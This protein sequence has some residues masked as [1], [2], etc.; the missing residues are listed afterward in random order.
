MERLVVEDFLGIREADVG[1]KKFNVIIG[2]QKNILT[3]L[4]YFFR[5]TLD[6]CIDTAILRD[7]NPEKTI[8]K[9]FILHFPKYLWENQKFN[10]EYKI[11][12]I[13]IRVYY[14]NGIRAV[15]NKTFKELITEIR[16]ARKN[17]TSPIAI[18]RYIKGSQASVNNTIY[19]PTG[20]N[21]FPKVIEAVSGNG[22]KPPKLA[23]TDLNLDLISREFIN[24]Y[25]IADYILER[26]ALFNEILDDVF[27]RKIKLEKHGTIRIDNQKMKLAD[28]PI[29]YQELV[30][31]LTILALPLKTKESK[32]FIIEEPDA[33]LFPKTQMEFLFFISKI[34][35][36]S[37]SP[38]LITTGSPYVLSAINLLLLA[39]NTMNKKNKDE[40]EKLIGK[41]TSLRF[42]DISAYQIENG[43]VKPF[44]NY[45]NRLLDTNIVDK[46][47][48]EH[49]ELFD[50]I[51]EIGLYEN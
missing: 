44:L 13:E 8:T 1:L 38:V 20:R 28:A 2:H 21:F 3:K 24:L 31:A 11:D 36:I 22:T 49:E 48:E 12:S 26:N 9:E 32:F 51:L 37:N 34:Y 41:D 30:P 18:D 50:R 29:E 19:I 5:K 33:Y 27:G 46:V 17:K 43:I 42:E 6:K 25:S 23:I 4:I 14:D 39:G 47:A 7:M 15:V 10:I 40:I 35:N 45:E 16:K